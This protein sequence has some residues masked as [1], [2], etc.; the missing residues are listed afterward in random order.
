MMSSNRHVLPDPGGMLDVLNLNWVSC[1]RTR[2]AV[3]EKGFALDGGFQNH[4]VFASQREH[5]SGGE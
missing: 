3:D 5:D 4:V 2:V 1:T